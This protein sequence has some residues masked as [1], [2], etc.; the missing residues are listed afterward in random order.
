[1]FSIKNLVSSPVKSIIAN[2][3]SANTTWFCRIYLLVWTL[4]VKN[5]VRVGWKWDSSGLTQC[6]GTLVQWIGGVTD[7]DV[8]LTEKP[9]GDGTGTNLLPILYHSVAMSG[10][11]T[12]SIVWYSTFVSSV[13]LCRIKLLKP[14]WY[15][16]LSML[17]ACL[18]YFL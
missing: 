1:M 13:S 15:H 2:S 17:S 9:A 18:K 4:S 5:L 6:L 14:V 16:Y 8:C 7:S 12:R 10:E 11:L 3:I